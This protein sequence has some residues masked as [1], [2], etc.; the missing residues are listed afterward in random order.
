VVAGLFAFALSPNCHLYLSATNNYLPDALTAVAG[1]S[2]AADSP[3]PTPT[4]PPRSSTITIRFVRDGQ[5]VDIYL[6]SVPFDHILADGRPCQ[7]ASAAVSGVD[8]HTVFTWPLGNFFGQAHECRKG[9]PTQITV[10]LIADVG[11]LETTL[12]WTG[13]DTIV[14]LDVAS[15]APT[16]AKLPDTGGPP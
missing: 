16:P 8:D 2:N 10:K 6:Y 1:A 7:Y 3:T 14:D 5:P 4:Y 13:S 9:P 15:T 11:H 12:S